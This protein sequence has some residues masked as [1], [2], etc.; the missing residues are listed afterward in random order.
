MNQI[1]ELI[2]IYEK[3]INIIRDNRK[4]I[5]SALKQNRKA[6]AVI[7]D[8]KTELKVVIDEQV[9]KGLSFYRI[10]MQNFGKIDKRFHIIYSLFSARTRKPRKKK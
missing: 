3:Q 2:S 10:C 8:V 6:K 7:A 4:M 9:E 1:E 5:K